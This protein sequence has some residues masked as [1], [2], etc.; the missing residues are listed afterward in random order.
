M[1]TRDSYMAEKISQFTQPVVAIVG[2]A[3]LQGLSEKIDPKKFSVLPVNLTALFNL[4]MP[5]TKNESQ[6][7]AQANTENEENQDIALEV[8]KRANTNATSFTPL[9]QH[10]NQLRTI[11]PVY[12]RLQSQVITPVTNTLDKLKKRFWGH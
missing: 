4:K 8:L 1:Q 2:A 9:S 11:I 5:A 12:Q 7:M 3:H 10:Y 6:R